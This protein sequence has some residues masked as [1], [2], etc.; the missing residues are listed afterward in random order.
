M[1]KKAK[2]MKDKVEW[3]VDV[4][5]EAKIKLRTKNVHKKADN[6]PNKYLN[7]CFPVNWNRK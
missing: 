4:K 5:K 3:K 6:E 1:K 7:K 2:R